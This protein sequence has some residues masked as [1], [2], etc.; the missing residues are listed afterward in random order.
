MPHVTTDKGIPN[1]KKIDPPNDIG[2][3][4][5]INPSFLFQK[6]DNSDGVKVNV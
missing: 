6:D 3:H 1:A 2:K 4:Q 5:G